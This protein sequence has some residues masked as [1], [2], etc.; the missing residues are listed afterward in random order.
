MRT[1]DQLQSSISQAPLK[2]SAAC[3]AKSRYFRR[4][5]G[6]N[7]RLYRVLVVELETTALGQIDQLP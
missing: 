4:I 3:Q 7:M 2:L 5:V 1:M 6:G